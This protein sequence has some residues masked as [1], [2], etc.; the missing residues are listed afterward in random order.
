VGDGEGQQKEPAPVR[1]VKPGFRGFVRSDARWL[2]QFEAVIEFRSTT[3]RFPSGSAARGST[4]LQLARWL[5]RQR[6]DGR[7]ANLPSDRLAAL[8][9]RLEGWDLR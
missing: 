1:S 8:E 6:Q 9:E 3:G 2:E 4:E 5:V 7:T